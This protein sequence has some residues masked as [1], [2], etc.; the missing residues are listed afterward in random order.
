MGKTVFTAK[1]LAAVEFGQNGPL[2][3]TRA[4]VE[5][6]SRIVWYVG[7]EGRIVQNRLDSDEWDLWV[8]SGILTLNGTNSDNWDESLEWDNLDLVDIGDYT[9]T[10]TYWNEWARIILIRVWLHKVGQNVTLV[11]KML[12]NYR[13]GLCTA[14]ETVEAIQ[15]FVPVTD[16]YPLAVNTD[17]LR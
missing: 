3:T 14:I 6:T 8:L 1:T 4:I 11:V 10:S 5:M 2:G 16:I 12:Q 7:D 17:K 15:M 9:D 13:N